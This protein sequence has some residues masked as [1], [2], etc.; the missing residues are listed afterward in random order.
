MKQNI[1]GVRYLLQLQW[2]DYTA[3][4]GELLRYNGNR[5]LN[6]LHEQNV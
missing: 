3:I 5:L 1:S 4:N 6:H 2:N